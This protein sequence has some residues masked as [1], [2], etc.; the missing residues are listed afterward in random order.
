MRA[1]VGRAVNRELPPERG[2]TVCHPDKPMTRGVGP[3]DAVVPDVHLEHVV[4]DRC[5]HLGVGSAR[6]FHDVGQGLGDDEIR[7][8]LYLGGKPRGP[9]IDLH[10]QVEPL[11][12]G[13]D[14]CPEPV[15][16]ENRGKD[17]VCELAQF[18]DAPLGVPQRIAD[19]PLRVTVARL[20]RI[21]S[22]LQRHDRMDEPLLGAVVEVSHHAPSRL[23]RL[24]EETRAGGRQLV[25]AV[26]V[27]DRHGEQLGELHH[28]LLGVGRRHLAAPLGDGHPPKPSFH[29]DRRAHDGA[30]ADVADQL[31]DGARAIPVVLHTGRLLSA[32]HLGRHVLPCVTEPRAGR[33]QLRARSAMREEGQRVVGLVPAERHAV[34]AEQP[35]HL[36]GDGVEDRRRGRAL[37]HEGRHAPQRRLLVGKLRQ[38]LAALRVRDRGHDQLGER[39]DP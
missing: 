7:A 23:V 37:S 29:H 3:T 39:P 6:V 24:G 21:L 18:R 38:R 34:G 22:E 33:C 27:R 2:H 10:W 30:N 5:R 32:A 15:M 28:P 31:R 4:L 19:E 8:R 14:P 11:H 16:R 12:E 9:K 25:A 20:E 1:A 26:R 35:F 17:A 13:V 36:G